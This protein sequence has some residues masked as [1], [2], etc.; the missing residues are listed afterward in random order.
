ME[1]LKINISKRESLNVI[2]RYDSVSI[3]QAD[4]RR[5]TSIVWIP[6]AEL[7]KVIE[8]LIRANDEMSKRK[9]GNK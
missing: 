8:Y 9:E 3:L 2:A 6:A 1:P 7:S 4:D 5:R